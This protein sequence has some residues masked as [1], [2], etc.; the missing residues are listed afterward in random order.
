MHYVYIIQSISHPEQIYVG[1][2][3]DI[4][5]RLSDHNSSNSP[6]T[7]KYKPWGIISYIAFTNKAKAYEFEEYL[8]S[9]SGRE[10]R[11]KRLI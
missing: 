1:C 10:F 7:A 11:N 8:K 6:H 9:G 3:Q 2:T 5:Q 4:K